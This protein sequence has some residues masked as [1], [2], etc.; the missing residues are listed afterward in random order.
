MEIKEIGFDVRVAIDNMTKIQVNGD[1]S[2]TSLDAPLA[3]WNLVAAG[4]FGKLVSDLST[5][6]KAELNK[7]SSKE[8]AEFAG[9]VRLFMG[10]LDTD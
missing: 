3:S 8:V 9:E 5:D 1:G 7:M 4:K 6:E 2:Y 10:K